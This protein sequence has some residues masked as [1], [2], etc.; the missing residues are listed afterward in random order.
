MCPEQTF[1]LAHLAGR[2]KS[3]SVRVLLRNLI[4]HE[5]PFLQT[6]PMA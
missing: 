2:K 1:A 3:I 4:H 5:T 6:L